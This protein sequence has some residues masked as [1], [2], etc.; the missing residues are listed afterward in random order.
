MA[1]KIKRV[2][3][4]ALDEVIKQEYQP[5]KV[6]EWNGIE[7]TIKTTL[8][9]QE[10]LRFADSVSKSCFDIATGAYLP[11]V[12]AFA[13]RCNIMDTYAN[14][15]LP[16]NNEHKYILAMCSGAVEMV[17]E[18]INMAQFN[19]LMDAID[20]KVDHLASAKVEMMTMKFD[21][22][23]SAFEDLQNRMGSL[24]E[25]VSADDIKKLTETMANYNFTDE[26][27]VKAYMEHKKVG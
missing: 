24:F 6:V 17:M 2:S 27:L 19:E 4:S 20:E 18:H 7:V 23:V 12:K 26:G 22:V 14:F 25:N 8:S 10:M 9:L 16:E 13:I 21:E 1:K 5:L 11:E 3:I 15:S